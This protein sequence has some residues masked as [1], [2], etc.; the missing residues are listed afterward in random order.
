LIGSLNVALVLSF[1]LPL[2]MCVS[3]APQLSVRCNRDARLLICWTVGLMGPL[4][5][6]KIAVEWLQFAHPPC[7]IS[8]SQ[9]RWSLDVDWSVE[10]EREYQ[11][12]IATCW[13]GLSARIQHPPLPKCHWQVMLQ[14]QT[15]H[16]S[17][18]SKPEKLVAHTTQ[19]MT[20]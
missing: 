2:C 14:A 16:Y 5:P 11:R 19:I 15:V 6:C 8:S 9:G 12:G 3:F 17:Q 18:D 7:P 20:K 4:V 13:T 10:R 1:R